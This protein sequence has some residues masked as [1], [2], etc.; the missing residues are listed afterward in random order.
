MRG[1]DARSEDDIYILPRKDGSEPTVA[2]TEKK[3]S[4][5]GRRTG[6]AIELGYR[7]DKWTEG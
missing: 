3:T 4:C 7:A 6:A 5:D 2:G 1:M